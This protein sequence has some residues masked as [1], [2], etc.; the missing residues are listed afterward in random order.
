MAFVALADFEALC[1]TLEIFLDERFL[2]AFA[3]FIARVLGLLALSLTRIIRVESLALV[4]EVVL[5]ALKLFAEVAEVAFV[6]LV[7]EVALAP[8][9]EVIA[10]PCI[11]FRVCRVASVL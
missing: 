9:A 7:A 3:R 4:A 1:A 6:A 11:A 10:L 2:V 8:F 5:F